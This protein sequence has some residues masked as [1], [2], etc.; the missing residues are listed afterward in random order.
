MPWRDRLEAWREQ[1]KIGGEMNWSMIVLI[2]LAVI[3]G[4]F[5]LGVIEITPIIE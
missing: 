5:L 2:V 1:M 3:F 4:L